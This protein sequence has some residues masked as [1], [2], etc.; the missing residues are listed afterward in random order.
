MAPVTRR[1]GNVAKQ[2]EPL[3]H[4]Y[5]G[6]DLPI[7]LRAWDGSETG[8]DGAAVTAVV[9]S[10]EALQHLLWAPGELGLARAHV[11][12]S[13]DIEGDIFGLFDLRDH[14]AERDEDLTVGLGVR[15]W[16]EMLATARR[17]GVVGR[18]PPLPPE[19][20]RMAG[21]LH[22]RRR[23]AAAI[24]HHYDVGNDF[25]RLLLG[26]S[27]VYSCAYWPESEAGLEA[28]QWAKCEL[29]SRKLGLRPGMRLLDVGCGWGTMAMHAAVE[30]G[31]HVVGVTISE[32]QADLARR[33]V[34]EAGLSD[35]VEIRVQDYRDVHDGPYD[36][37]SSIGMFE[38]VGRER[39][40]RYFRDL[41]GLLRPGGRLLNHAISR[42]DPTV[43]GRISPRSFIGRYVFPDGTL[44]EVG[45][46]I[47]AMQ[48]LGFEVRDLQS[49]R[50]HYALTLRAW[51]ANLENE[52]DRAQ[53]L[54]GPGRARVW[55]LYLAG[56]AIAFEHNRT[57]VHQ[58]LA[59]RPHRSGE[60][61]M[62][63]TRQDFEVASP[64]GD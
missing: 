57:A 61:D 21:F 33:R 34:A 45:T 51:V 42:P 5:L 63:A 25:Y 32:E 10:P 12:G 20:T 6:P 4:A 15:D 8:P 26:P 11:S 17:L 50:E 14:V 37:I 16:I 40:A 27:L 23:D 9:H 47:T 41:H 31:A 24:S 2:L 30:H 62:P 59:V 13:L 53:R 46:V 64:V 55:R 39:M 52:W 38:H 35:Q 49:L 19:E 56:S 18:R 29:I 3:L 22:S 60:S 1:A 28:A 54:V 7:R 58:V 44:L 48:E 43:H 36:A